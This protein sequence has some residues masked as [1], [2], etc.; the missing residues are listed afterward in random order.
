M[1]D[2]PDNPYS[3]V[4][5]A[6][7]QGMADATS[8]IVQRYNI[9]TLDDNSNIVPAI[10]PGD[11]PGLMFR[12]YAIDMAL[13]SSSSTTDVVRTF[14]CV[15]IGNNRDGAEINEI[16]WCMTCAMTTLIDRLNAL[17]W[18]GKKFFVDLQLNTS[19]IDRAAAAEDIEL[20][21][22]CWVSVW[23][24][25]VAMRFPSEALIQQVIQ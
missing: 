22:G 21:E 15:V 13:K 12:A 19:F 16:E 24:I 3:L 8:E 11:T 6:L 23:P 1:S 7:I 10:S 14:R 18:K 17:V 25:K 2:Q 20:S 9:M 4:S 5:R